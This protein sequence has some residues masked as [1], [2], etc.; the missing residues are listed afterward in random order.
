MVAPNQ[1]KIHLNSCSIWMQLP[2]TMLMLEAVMLKQKAMILSPVAASS[3]SFKTTVA[4]FVPVELSLPEP[5]EGTRGHLPMWLGQRLFPPHRQRVTGRVFCPNAEPTSLVPQ[6]C[7]LL[8][9]F[10]SPRNLCSMK[11]ALRDQ[12]RFQKLSMW[13]LTLLSAPTTSLNPKLK[14]GQVSLRR[15]VATVWVV[16]S[17][18]GIYG[19]VMAPSTQDCHCFGSG[20]PPFQLAWQCR[21][22]LW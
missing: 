4:K 17:G 5:Q 2:C 21:Y 15:P 19:A 20:F 18:L 22:Q 7:D 16:S 8:G 1:S 14:R 13:T 3:T 10:L 11:R 12:C 9:G 6:L